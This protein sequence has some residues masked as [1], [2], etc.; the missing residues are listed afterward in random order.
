MAEDTIKR[1]IRYLNDAHAMEAGALVALTDLSQRAD[2]PE[3]KQLAKSLVAIVE[4]Q[5]ARLAQR[6]TELGGKVNAA[7]ALFDGGL[8]TGNRLTNAF[9]DQ[10]D[11]ETQDVMKSYGLSHFEVAVYTSLREYSDGIGDSQTARLAQNLIDEEVQA[12]EKLLAVLPRVAR[13]PTYT[14]PRPSATAKSS[15]GG[16]GGVGFPAI[17]GGVLVAGSTALAAWGVSQMLAKKNGGS[18]APPATRAPYV[19]LEEVTIVTEPGT[20]VSAGMIDDIP[21]SGAVGTTGTVG[22]GDIYGVAPIA[23][24]TPATV[25]PSGQLA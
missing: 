19:E 13:I 6:I 25:T 16:I 18:S 5:I 22:N 24:S 1:Q 10:A 3:V 8:A 17:A 7:K 15:S 9:H 11:K 14:T 12:A 20:L 23:D 4:T 21:T 2:T